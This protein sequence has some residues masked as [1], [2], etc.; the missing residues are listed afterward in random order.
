MTEGISPKPSVGL[1]FC[2]GCLELL[3]TGNLRRDFD[4]NSAHCGGDVMNERRNVM[5]ERRIKHN[6]TPEEAQRLKL[7]AQKLPFGKERDELIRQA[8]QAATTAHLNE[9]LSSPGLK[10]PN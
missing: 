6:H 8:R 2:S 7:K 1:D 9:W 5:N 3:L 4:W 10:P